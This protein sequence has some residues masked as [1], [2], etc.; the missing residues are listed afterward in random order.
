M[1]F[2]AVFIQMHRHTQWETLVRR[3]DASDGGP[4]NILEFEMLPLSGL[5]DGD[6]VLYTAGDVIPANAEIVDGVASMDESGMRIL[7]G[8]IAVRITGSKTFRGQR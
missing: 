6:L 5:R 2:D 4:I 3:L 8:W 7:S 1:R